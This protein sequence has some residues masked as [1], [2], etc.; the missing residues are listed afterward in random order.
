MQ[1]TRAAG[2]AALALFLATPVPVGAAG[3]AL[4]EQG[5]RGMGLAG[6]FTAQANDPSAIFHN[7]AGVA[8]Q[9]GR[10]LY[11]GGVVASPSTSFVGADPFPG[12]GRSEEM[13][14]GIIPF[15]TLYYTQSLTDDLAIGVGVHVPYRLKTQWANPQ[16]FSGRFITTRAE[17]KGFSLNPTL[18]WK[19]RDR[20]AIGG[21]VDVRFSSVALER[22]VPGFNP[23]TLAVTDVAT[24]LVESDTAMDLGFN[25]GVLAK[26]SQSLSLGAS[27]RHKL[28][29]SFDGSATFSL[30]PSG[31]AQFDA[32]VAQR[33]PSGSIPATTEIETPSILSLGAAWTWNDWTLEGDVNFYGWSSFDEL[34]LEIEN[35]PDLSSISNE[36]YENSF[37]VRLGADRRLN[38]A[39]SVRGGYFFDQSPSPTESVS[40]LLPDSDR[41]GICLGGSFRRG[42]LNLDAGASFVLSNARSTEGRNR[43][44]FDGT[45]DSSAVSLGVSV[46]Y[47]F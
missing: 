39:W 23:F 31:S 22:S 17:F 46:G 34:P 19:L 35:R 3:F 41:H 10:Q 18:A 43:D 25:L 9:K 38:D 13:D 36:G 30:L 42:N 24:A 12:A 16:T 1:R 15:P 11:L 26:P 4:F 6:A 47:R 5:A 20:L 44:G 8:Y 45:Y 33:L 7:A 2:L 14:T 40:V 21:G 32:V 37:Q 28:R 29:Q 27:Y